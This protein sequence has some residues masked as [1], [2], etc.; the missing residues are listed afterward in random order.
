MKR[1]LLFLAVFL[2]SCENQKTSPSTTPVQ[3]VVK[4]TATDSTNDCIELLNYT[5]VFY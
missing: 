5:S 1:L 3:P 4:K 2:F